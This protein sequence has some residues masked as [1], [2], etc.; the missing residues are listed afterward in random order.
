MTL[1][2][3]PSA[4]PASGAPAPPTVLR[5]VVRATVGTLS[6]VLVLALV[7]V[8][9]VYGGAPASELW[10]KALGDP[11]ITL[12]DGATLS[13]ERPTADVPLIREKR[14]NLD[15]PASLAAF[16]APLGGVTKRALT[17][18][19]ADT[20]RAELEGGAPTEGLVDGPVASPVILT[21]AGLVELWQYDG[22]PDT[23]VLTGTTGDGALRGATPSQRE[24]L[25]LELVAAWSGPSTIPLAVEERTA[26]SSA[27]VQVVRSGEESAGVGQPFVAFLH[28]RDGR[29]WSAMVSA[30]SASGSES[31][32]LLSPAE[33]FDAVRHHRAGVVARADYVPVVRAELTYDL[34]STDSGVAAFWTFYGADGDAAW[35]APADPDLAPST[36]PSWYG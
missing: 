26:G 16:T 20:W 10:A 5:Q 2:D 17:L 13:D 6:V 33:A 4:E 3:Q 32:T 27:A 15:D 28:F 21:P 19:E 12:A 9:A 36:I 34:S 29:L 35:I 8:G 18:R 7:A 23:I 25:A 14:W 22:A 1:L 31:R 11:G 30:V 24:S